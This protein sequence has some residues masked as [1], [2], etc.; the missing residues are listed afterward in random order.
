M[1][2]QSGGGMRIRKVTLSWGT[3]A[4][5]RSSQRIEVAL[6]SSRPRVIRPELLQHCRVSLAQQIAC[7]LELPQILE[8]QRKIGLAYGGAHRCVRTRWSSPMCARIDVHY[9]ATRAD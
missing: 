2:A 6:Y 1:A 9:N 7:F 5:N 3:P 8:D 4:P